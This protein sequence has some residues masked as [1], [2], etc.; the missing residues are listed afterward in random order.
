MSGV[1]CSD[2]D[3]GEDYAFTDC[4]ARV[5]VSGYVGEEEQREFFYILSGEEWWWAPLS[6]LG[7]ERDEL[8]A[9]YPEMLS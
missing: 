2:D 9:L 7:M 6:A 5:I 1:V 4:Q 8:I 3:D